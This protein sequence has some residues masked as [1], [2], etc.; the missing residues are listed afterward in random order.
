MSKAR[1]ERGYSLE[2]GATPEEALSHFNLLSGG[3]PTHGA[4]LLFGET[5][6]RLLPAADLTCLH[7]TGTEIAKPIASQQVFDGTLFELVDKAVAFVMERMWREVDP[8]EGTPES[9]VQYELP[10]DA[11]REAVVNAVAHRNYASHSGVQVTVFRD[12]VEIWNPGGL[13]ED[14]TVEQLRLPH[15]S[16]PRNRRISEPLYLAHY[17]ERAGTG[18]LDIIRRCRDAGLADPEFASDGDRF[19]AILWRDWLT[20][21][22]MADR[23]LT[24]RQRDIVVHVKGSVRV[25]NTEVQQLLGVSK[26][27][28]H[29]DLAEL[30]D[31]GVLRQVGKTGKGTHYVLAKG[32]R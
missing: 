13:P 20:P 10:Y 23:A 26:R 24:D 4:V 29:R 22:V 15:P 16:V 9:R 30:V 32:A 5:P 11:V 7:F 17:I 27:T 28:A 31:K 1:T 3:R 25:T 18:T 6:Q 12:R 8:G 21:A 2:V 19:V 14:L